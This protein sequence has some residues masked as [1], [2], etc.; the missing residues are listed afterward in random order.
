[1]ATTVAY[2]EN[3]VVN[4]RRAMVKKGWSQ[5]ELARRAQLHWQTVGRILSGGMTPTT[6]TAEKIADALN[7]GPEKIFRKPS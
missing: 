5:R 3:F 2:T 6:D 4:V 1:M 7:L